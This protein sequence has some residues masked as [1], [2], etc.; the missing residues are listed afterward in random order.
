ML[1]SS[2]AYVFYKSGVL[3]NGAKFTE[4]QVSQSLFLIK[5]SL[6]LYL[7]KTPAQLFFYEFFK[8][9]KGKSV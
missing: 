8:I 7:K 9:I 2:H 5:L 6:Q 3:Q 1:R 4:K